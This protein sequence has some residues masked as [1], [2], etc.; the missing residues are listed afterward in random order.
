M[1]TPPFDRTE[2]WVR[3]V[4]AFLFFG[5]VTALILLRHIDSLGIPLGIG[6]WAG[7]TIGISLAAARAGDEAWNGLIRFFRWWS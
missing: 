6:I 3:F 1:G 4:F 5:F 2:F 7:C